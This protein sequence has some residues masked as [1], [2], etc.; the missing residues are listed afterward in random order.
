MEKIT[1]KKIIFVVI[2]MISLTCHGQVKKGQKIIYNIPPNVDSIISLY[3]DSLK[4]HLNKNEIIYA[5]IER[6]DCEQVY[7]C[8]YT[9]IIDWYNKNFLKRENWNKN[10]ILFGNRCLKIKKAI[11]PLIINGYDDVFINQK[12]ELTEGGRAR[13][14]SRNV[15]RHSFYIIFKLN[16][17][18]IDVK[19][20]S[21]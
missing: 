18:I 9:I 4:T 1:I 14:L 6:N 5:I 7:S 15:L 2:C 21:Y 3:Y 20:S 12:F 17:E 11:L 19:N 13:Y 10:V 16:N 8:N